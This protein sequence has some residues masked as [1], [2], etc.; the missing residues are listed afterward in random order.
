MTRI[1]ALVA[2]LCVISVGLAVAYQPIDISTP[3]MTFTGG[4]GFPPIDK[5]TGTMM[6]TGQ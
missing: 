5:T 4:A 6:F 3:G 1:L 2:I